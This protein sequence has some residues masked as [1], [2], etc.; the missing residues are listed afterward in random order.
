MNISGY[1]LDLIANI[2][3]FKYLSYTINGRFLSDKKGVPL[4]SDLPTIS[5]E[6]HG[7]SLPI[8]LN[9]P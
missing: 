3:Y 4:D 7:E 5:S 1:Q 6:P 8:T 2:T 9:S